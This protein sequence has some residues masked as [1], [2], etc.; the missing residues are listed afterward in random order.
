MRR[1]FVLHAGHLDRGARERVSHAVGRH[2]VLGIDLQTHEMH[3]VRV[4]EIDDSVLDDLAV[5]N[6]EINVIVG[7]E[8]RGAPVDLAHFA[9]GIA[10]LQPVAD[11]VGLADLERDA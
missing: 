4:T 9:V 8:P 7:A 2:A 11:L 1:W 3:P 10:K 5:R 6:V